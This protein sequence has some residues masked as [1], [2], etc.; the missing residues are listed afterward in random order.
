MSKRVSRDRAQQAAFLRLTLNCRK[1]NR[2]GDKRTETKVSGK[3]AAKKAAHVGRQFR[4]LRANFSA[5]TAARDTTS[6]RHGLPRDAPRGWPPGA[7]RIGAQLRLVVARYAAPAARYAARRHAAA[8][9]HDVATTWCR[10][11]A[12]V[13]HTRPKLLYETQPGPLEIAAHGE[14]SKVVRY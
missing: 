10:Y 2:E 13:R 8:P 4:K 7:G 3:V 11:A 12:Q 5:P 1:S 6:M 9:N 14:S